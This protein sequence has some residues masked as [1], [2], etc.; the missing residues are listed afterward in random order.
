MGPP[1]GGF[2]GGGMP[3]GPPGGGF[4][5][6]GMPWG[7]PGGGFPGGG[8]PGGGPSEWVRR[9]DTNGNGMLDPDESQGR[10]RMFLE[11]T[12]LDLSRPIPMDRVT[13]AFE[14]MR[15]RRGEDGGRG[16]SEEGGSGDP[17]SAKAAV[18]SLVP[19]FGEPD[20]FDPVPG[21]GD[22][23]EKFA[24]SIEEEDRQ[25]ALR[26]MGR[27]DANQDGVLDAD[28]IR[29]GRWSDDPLQTD[30]NRDGK[31]TL[32]E[33]ALR[34]AIRRVERE[35]TGGSKRSTARGSGGRAPGGG[36][37]PGP[38]AGPGGGPGSG[39][40]GGPERMQQMMFA[41]FDRNSNGVLERYE[42]D[43][44]PFDAERVDANH[45]GR[46]T[47]EEFAAAMSS[48]F[49][50]RRGG[51]EGGEGE[52][53]RWFGRREGENPGGGG[54]GGDSAPAGAHDTA[55]ESTAKSYRVRTSVERLANFSGLPDWFGRMD[56]NGD[57][58]VSM[59]EYSS[60]WNEQTAADFA[61]FDLNN[62]G[63]VTPAECLKAAESGAVQ[64]A[65]VISAASAT[66]AE[67]PRDRRRD[68]RRGERGWDRGGE[69]GGERREESAAAPTTA[70]ADAPSG[71]SAGS[72]PD[73]AAPSSATPDS[74]APSSA[75]P[76]SAASGSSGGAD[77]Q[78]YVKYAVGL[79]RQY[80]TN[81]D[82]VLTQEEWSKMNTDYSAADTDHDGRITP[83]ELA[84]AFMKK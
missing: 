73:S 45:D 35:G 22:L 6:G 29:N 72:A 46:I 7:P 74:A 21:F 23:G 38:E 39:P 20:L 13:Q 82:G 69:R 52:R 50:G 81:K 14:D 12:G 84:A 9:L 75:T 60:S 28:E 56:A 51:S 5:G 40:G 53:G 31:L 70:S 24:V 36:T 3:M 42:W 10:A 19:G 47:R 48:R 76:S 33:L 15:N 54:G 62:D 16:R 11:R 57:G 8:F 49:G 17:A 1:G 2:P 55:H 18:S 65:P 83:V 37:G 58:Q 4:P 67:Q 64:G 26:T 34:Y 61:Q 63:I 32:T 43:G 77:M 71:P 30:R 78:K 79:I 59:A 41:R 44:V 68:D 27:S 66:S 80:D 25:E